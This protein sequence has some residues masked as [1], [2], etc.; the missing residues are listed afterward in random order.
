MSYQKITLVGNLGKDPEMKTI[1]NDAMVCKFS[2]ACNEKWK[3]GEHTEWFSVDVFGAQ[4][5]PCLKYLAKGRKVLVEGTLRT[6]E[7][8]G[9][10]YTSLRASRVVFLGD[11][12]AAARGPSDVPA[13]TSLSA[14][15]ETEIPF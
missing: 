7:K 9:K 1:G 6:N 4:A 5:E 12:A 3:G 8:D 13:D 2:V 15:D 14:L 10:R 11:T